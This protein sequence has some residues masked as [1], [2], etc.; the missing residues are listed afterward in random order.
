MKKLFITILLVLFVLTPTIYAEEP[1]PT[2]EETENWIR[3]TLKEYGLKNFEDR[4]FV[5]YDLKCKVEHYIS[6][7]KRPQIK[8]DED[9]YCK[10]NTEDDSLNV[11]ARGRISK[12]VKT[13]INNFGRMNIEFIGNCGRDG[14]GIN[15]WAI[16][17]SD[18]QKIKSIDVL[19]VYSDRIKCRGNE[20][21]IITK[22]ICGECK[23]ENYEEK[24]EKQK[25]YIYFTNEIMASKC[26]IALNHL[27]ALY[28]KKYPLK[29]EL[30]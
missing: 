1:K 2:I 24:E 10:T 25:M 7:E 21:A 20:V 4:Y 22:Q 23:N 18:S 26:A 5:K 6:F 13:N 28:L 15:G 3:D 30:F 11:R 27:K 17:I 14:Y 19:T 8:Y 9:I 29:K 12:F 16:R